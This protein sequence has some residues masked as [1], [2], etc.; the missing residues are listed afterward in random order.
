MRPLLHLLNV[1]LVLPVVALA[2]AFLV[3]GHAVSTQSWVGFFDVLL[4]VFVWLL[5]WGLLVC[6]V[7]LV[8]LILAGLTPRFR[9]WASLCVAALATIGTAVVLVTIV[10]HDNFSPEQ[11]VFFAPSLACAAFG[12]WLAACEKRR[13]PDPTA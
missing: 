1:L 12:V 3:F 13:G 11:L 8:L 5:P 9:W 6:F 4:N 7:S 2:A 10:I